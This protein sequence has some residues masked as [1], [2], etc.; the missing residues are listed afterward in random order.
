MLFEIL[1]A[2]KIG[3]NTMKQLTKTELAIMNA[4]TVFSKT[5][6]DINNGLGKTEN[7]IKKSTNV[8]LGKKV[9]K[10]IYKGY[11]IFTL[12]LEVRKT[13]PRSC[14]HW[15]NCYGNN[16]PFATRYDVHVMV[17]AHP[18]KLSER[19][20]G[21]LPIPTLY[22]IEDSRHWYNKCDVGMVVHRISSDNFSVV[23]V[24]KSRYHDILGT[25]GE[26]RFDFNKDTGRYNER[27]E[28]D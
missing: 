14:K 8:K 16:M 3:L 18:T 15:N 4:T 1:T 17:V 10:G 27:F 13:C 23:R 22:S 5:V 20:D 7:L 25:P 11:P 24:V 12:T 19:A 2:T 9:T 28:I 6:K 21:T 26:V